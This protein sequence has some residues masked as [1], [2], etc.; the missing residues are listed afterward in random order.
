MENL[1]NIKPSTFYNNEQK[2][3]SGGRRTSL[4][5]IK[6]KVKDLKSKFEYS[7]MIKKNYQSN[8]DHFQNIENSLDKEGLILEVIIYII[9]NL[10]YKS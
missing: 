9:H 8:S 3:P 2:I 10:K 5:N 1:K 7:Q 4:K 6:I